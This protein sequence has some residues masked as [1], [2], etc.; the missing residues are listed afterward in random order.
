MGTPPARPVT[1]PV[2]SP[3]EGELSVDIARG[4]VEVK[5]HSVN[6]SNHAF[7]DESRQ[8]SV[9]FEKRWRRDPYASSKVEPDELG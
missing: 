9:F 5:M 7:L 1:T 4:S 6:A 2:T 3:D 8:V